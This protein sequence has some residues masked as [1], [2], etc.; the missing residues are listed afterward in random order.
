MSEDCEFP[1]DGPLAFPTRH[2]ILANFRLHGLCGREE[3][4]SIPS[5]IEKA[6]NRLP[7][8]LKWIRLRA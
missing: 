8:A 5:L 7:T 1:R 4:E 2:S 3:Q 6:K